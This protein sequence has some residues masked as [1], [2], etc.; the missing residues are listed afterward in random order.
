MALVLALALL[1]VGVSDTTVALRGALQAGLYATNFAVGLDQEFAPELAHLW[2]LAVEEQFYVAWPVVLVLI[3]RVAR[4]RGDKQ[5]RWIV[6]LLAAGVLARLVTILL[7]QE[8]GWFFYALPTT[9]LDCFMAGALLATWTVSRSSSL[10]QPRWVSALPTS[11]SILT[12]T[13]VSLHPGAFL[14]ST[15]YVLGVPILTAATVCLIGRAVLHPPD[16]YHGLLRMAPIQWLGDRSYGLYL[17]NS[18]CVLTAAVWLGSGL[19]SRSAGI[20]AAV[21][22]A[23]VS[24]RFIERPALR[25]RSR[26][27]DHGVEPDVRGAHERITG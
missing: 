8:F 22:L 10:R 20:L 16:T 15:T 25:L 14:S 12:I 1:G 9:W 26:A 2:T 6:W 17:F 21:V 23:E 19:A 5:I 27:S 3:L 4:S 7:S 18:T 13:A 24:R 11:L